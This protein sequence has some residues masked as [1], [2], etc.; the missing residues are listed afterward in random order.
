MADKQPKSLAEQLAVSTQ[1]NGKK[2]VNG[3]KET[4]D[5]A[6]RQNQ[7]SKICASLQAIWN[8][9]PDWSFVSLISDLQE[10]ITELSGKD[11]DEFNAPI[12]DTELQK[13]IDI[14]QFP[15]H[16]KRKK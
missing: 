10:H 2:I 14:M 5:H 8:T 9:H 15:A 1:H 7:I 13:I 12:S 4:I 16:L 6:K 3:L 11:L